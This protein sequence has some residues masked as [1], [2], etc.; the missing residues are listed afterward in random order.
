MNLNN[1]E[2]AIEDAQETIYRFLM[3]L[4]KQDASN[5]AMIAF[6]N[7]FIEQRTTTLEVD[8]ALQTLLDSHNEQEFKNLLKRCCYILLNHW[9]GRRNHQLTQELIQVLSDSRLNLYPLDTRFVQL[10]NWLNNFIKSQDYEEIKLFVSKYENRET[11]SWTERY[12]SFLLVPQYINE[13][14]PIEQRQAAQRFSKHLKEKFK[15]ELALYTARVQSV[16]SR[17]ENSENPTVLGDDVLLFIKNIVARRG[18]TNYASLAKTFLNQT[19][20]LTYKNFKQSLLMYLLYSEQ[21]T[22]LV[23]TL[24]TLLTR[25]VERLYESYDEEPIN[26][27]LL[28]MVCNKIIK[29]LTL[30]KVGAPSSIFGLLVNQGNPLTLAIMLLKLVLISPNS[31]IRLEVCLALLIKHY[32]GKSAKKCENFIKFLEICKILLTIYA[33]NVQYNLVRMGEGSQENQD[34]V[35]LEGY[36]VFSQHKFPPKSSKTE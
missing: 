30:E 1:A 19:R 21:E 10:R 7:L 35:S 24:R 2:Q 16:N 13:K 27:S 15:F 17:V 14:N 8:S 36:R 28:L 5:A 18:S 25:K 29:I 12:T 3:E 33:E 23:K 9:I 31:R 20:D 26:N 34:I 4:V 32:E 22:N 6:K 11:T